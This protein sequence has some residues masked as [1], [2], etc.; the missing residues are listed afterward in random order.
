MVDE[1]QLETSV[2]E[3]GV[4]A[5][6]VLGELDVATADR[7]INAFNVW[8]EPINECVV[9]LSGCDFVDSSGIRALLLCRQQLE[10]E[11]RRMRLVG[12]T[13]NVERTFTTAGMDAVFQFERS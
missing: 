4:L 7:L 1:F 5:M 8:R 10:S 6:R 11:N 2:T 3:S 9:D 13:P 12:L